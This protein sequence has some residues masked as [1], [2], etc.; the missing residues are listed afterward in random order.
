[1]CSSKSEVPIWIARDS[2]TC[3]IVLLS[4]VLRQQFIAADTSEESRFL[5]PTAKTEENQKPHVQLRHMGHRPEKPTEKNSTAIK[6]R[7][8]VADDHDQADAGVARIDEVIFA[9]DVFD[10]HVVVVVPVTG[11]RLRVVEPEAAVVEAITAAL[12]VEVVF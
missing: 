1:L 8:L 2:S 11:P 10:V 9:V 3:G 12:H 6:L 7:R 5:K 4:A